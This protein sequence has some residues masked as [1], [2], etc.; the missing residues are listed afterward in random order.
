M[1][2]RIKNA[3]KAGKEKVNM[4][5]SGL[6][7][8]ICEILKREGFIEDYSVENADVVSNKNISIKLAYYES[9]KPTVIDMKTTSTPGIRFYKKAKD[10]RVYKNG[11]GIFSFFLS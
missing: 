9:K 11:L 7:E 4:P 3:Y 2:V 8:N 1:I 5:Y 6:K 10:I